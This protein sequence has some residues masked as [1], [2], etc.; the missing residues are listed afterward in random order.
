MASDS[1]KK[2]VFSGT[3]WMAT[4]SCG[5][6]VLQFL[7]QIV[8]ARLLVP[9]DYGAAA[10]VMCVCAF[11]TV[12][13]SAGIGVA[14]VQRKELPDSV[15]DAAAVITGGMALLLGGIVF[16]VSG[17]IAVCY[18]LPELLLLFRIAAIDIF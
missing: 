3:L 14:L 6:Q 4:I 9:H 17:W 12:F 8:L 11:A 13:S 5:Q 10:I 15:K 1:I 7:L 18:K 2:T 16:A